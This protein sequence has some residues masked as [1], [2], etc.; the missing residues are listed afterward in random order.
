MLRLLFTANIVP[1][2]PILVTLM[3]VPTR[4]TW[5]NIPDDNILH[6]LRHEKL[7]SYKEEGKQI[8][9][10]TLGSHILD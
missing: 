9:Y 1:S 10:I 2:L 8:N 4:A 5:H 3:M 6:S 7:K